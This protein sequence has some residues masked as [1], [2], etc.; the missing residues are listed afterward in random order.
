MTTSAKLIAAAKQHAQM[1]ENADWAQRKR[2][3]LI[4]TRHAEGAS[5][6]TIADEAGV[7]HQTIVNIV[8]RQSSTTR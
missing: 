6:R 7:S 2:D 5:L 3:R 8:R 4:V 1:Q